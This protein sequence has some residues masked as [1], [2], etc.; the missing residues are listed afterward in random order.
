VERWRVGKVV[1]S[2]FEAPVFVVSVAVSVA[3]AAPVVVAAP[4]VVAVA[5]PVPVVVAVDA[6]DACSFWMIDMIDMNSKKVRRP[7]RFIS[8]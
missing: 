6:I 5:V 8:L 1:Q 4:A 2:P 7:V 3:V